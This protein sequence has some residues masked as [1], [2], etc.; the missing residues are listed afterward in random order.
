LFSSLQ[1]AFHYL[2]AF[3][4]LEKRPHPSVREYRLDR[5]EA[6]LNSFDDPHRH[7]RIF[8]LAGSKGKG[9]TGIFLTKLLETQGLQV[10]LYT[11]PHVSSYTERISLGGRPF[12]PEVYLDQINR[13]QKF[14]QNEVPFP[15][16]PEEI[17]QEPTTFELLTLLAFLVFAD[18]EVDAIVLETGLGG[19][20][21]ATNLVSP[22]ATLIT[23]IELEHTQILG[24]T[25][26]AIAG[27][28]AGIIK[29]GVPLFLSHQPPEAQEVFERVAQ[30][31]NAPLLP[32]DRFSWQIESWDFNSI[33]I[34]QPASVSSPQS[35]AEQLPLR[36]GMAG[37]F[38]GQN[39]L[40]ALSCFD[41]F[42]PGAAKAGWQEAAREAHLPGR[43][44]V[45]SDNPW[46]ILDGG[47]TPRAMQKLLDSLGSLK[48]KP[49]TLLFGAVV[50]KDIL[51]MA[52]VLSQ[53]FDRVILTKAGNFRPSDLQ[54]MER[55]FDQAGF[56][57]IHLFSQARKAWEFYQLQKTQN[58]D[59]YQ[60]GLL[61]TGSF[62]L[63]GEV[64]PWL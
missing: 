20:L 22:V 17:S 12:A 23:P 51:G 39:F 56:T 5:M 9:S 14:L 25:L 61:I 11:S 28:K 36:L 37:D 35:P 63:I 46:I 53:G 54:A 3:T 26:S 49:Q 55:A 58:P 1:E 6:L 13:I 31:K 41:H 19:R 16:L 45:V 2:E 44:E 18:Q 8:H 32:L 59:L 21:D 4:N 30:E 60:G 24:N 43:M 34:A 47:H 52:E 29:P 62:F 48:K 7:P 27:E 42:Y 64:K 38:Q 40:L 15:G 50:G 57:Q 33:L 10:G